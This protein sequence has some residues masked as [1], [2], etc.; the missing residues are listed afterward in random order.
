MCG[1]SNSWIPQGL[2]ST[3]EG[4]S[5]LYAFFNVINF[6]VTH[7]QYEGNLV[8]FSV[9]CVLKQHYLKCIT[10]VENNLW[11]GNGLWPTVSETPTEQKTSI[12]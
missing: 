11:R 6:Y 12:D 9:K 4:V 10:T 7:I 5:Y 2:S 1:A 8:V 3:V